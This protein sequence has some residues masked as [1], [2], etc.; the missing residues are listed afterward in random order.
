MKISIETLARAINKQIDN[1]EYFYA[2]GTL[3][4][5]Y[6]GWNDDNRTLLNDTAQFMLKQIEEATRN[7]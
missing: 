1:N 3:K 2:Y 6:V 7:V 4:E 5:T